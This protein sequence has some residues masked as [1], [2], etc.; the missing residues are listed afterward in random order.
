[1]YIETK[2]LAH[3]A[4]GQFPGFGLRNFQTESEE[5][6]MFCRYKFRDNSRMLN[7]AFTAYT[8]R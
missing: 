8:S 4:I 7:K 1:M 2:G 6:P 5:F 3:V